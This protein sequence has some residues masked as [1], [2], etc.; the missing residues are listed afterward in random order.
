MT[1]QTTSYRVNHTFEVEIGYDEGE[2]EWHRYQAWCNGLAGCMVYESTRAKA[3]RKIRQAIVAWLEL[4]NRQMDD[5]S[6]VTN[7][8]DMAVPD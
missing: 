1:H 8:I 6:A 3:L 4:A 2:E 7:F 5:Q